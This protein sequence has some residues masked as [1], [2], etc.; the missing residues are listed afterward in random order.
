MLLKT[1]SCI[2]YEVFKLSKLLGVGGQ[3]DMF[4]SHIFM[5][6]PP[7]IDASAF[8]VKTCTPI[9]TGARLQLLWQFRV[10]TWTIIVLCHGHTL[11]E[12]CTVKKK[13]FRILSLPKQ[14][15]NII[16]ER[17]I[18]LVKYI[19][20]T[21]RQKRLCTSKYRNNSFKVLKILLTSTGLTNDYSFAIIQKFPNVWVVL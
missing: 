4:A 11:W 16:H 18:I 9:K 2:T 14:Y 15:S 17:D 19:L 13:S 6:P 20:P 5:P 12:G 21:F 7:R 1:Y 3:N 8:W 10:Q